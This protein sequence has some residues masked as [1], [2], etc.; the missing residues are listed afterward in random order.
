MS[1]SSLS[2]CGAAAFVCLLRVR[3]SCFERCSLF[4]GHEF[5]HERDLIFATFSSVCACL[6]CL[7]EKTIRTSWRADIVSLL[8][9]KLFLSLYDW[10]V[11]V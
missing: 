8:K 10:F 7:H 2:L 6:H 1:S 3:D 4:K 9:F 5:N 11:A